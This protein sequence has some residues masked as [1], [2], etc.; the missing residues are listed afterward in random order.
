LLDDLWALW[1][2]RRIDEVLAWGLMDAVVR[3]NNRNRVES[4]RSRSASAERSDRVFE[5]G[6]ASR[7]VGKYVS[8][9]QRACMETPE[10]VNARYAARKGTNRDSR[11]STPEPSS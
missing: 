2:K 10:V 9:M 5:G 7:T 1:R 4:N 11:N 3:Q 8:V 6:E